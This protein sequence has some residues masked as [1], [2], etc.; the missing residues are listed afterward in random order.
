MKYVDYL[1]QSKYENMD[2][3]VKCVINVVIN[4]TSGKKM[5]RRNRCK[6]D[7]LS[8]DKMLTANVLEVQIITN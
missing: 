6:V 1:L 4:Q 7:W 2:F 3:K 8:K 5:K